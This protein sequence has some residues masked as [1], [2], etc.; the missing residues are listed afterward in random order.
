MRPGRLTLRLAGLLAVGAFLLHQLRYLADGQAFAG[1]DHSYLPF[2]LALAGVL[3]L[4]ACAGFGRE[5]WHAS[6]GRVAPASQPSFTATWAVAAVSLLSIFAIQE[7]IEAGVAPGHPTTPAHALAHIGWL[8]LLLAG[9]LGA[10]IAALLRG[11]QSALNLIAKRHAPSR[12]PRPAS[13]R[14]I[15]LPSPALPRLDVLATLGAER[16]P[17]SIPA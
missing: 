3:L 11:A 5:L 14:G 7:W 13:G 8:G 10:M 16:A 17:P 9:S 1:H 6:R 2:A 12:R 15:P 4:L